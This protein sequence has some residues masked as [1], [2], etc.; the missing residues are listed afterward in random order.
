MRVAVAVAAAAALTALA[1]N[2][3][4]ASGVAAAAQSAGFAM[5]PAIPSR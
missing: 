2:G 4:R 1:E 3:G 5:M